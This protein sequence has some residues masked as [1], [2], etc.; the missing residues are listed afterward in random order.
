[1]YKK[2]KH[3]R[4][5]LFENNSPTPTS[6][7]LIDSLIEDCENEFINEEQL[8]NYIDESFEYEYQQLLEEGFIDILKA[9]GKTKAAIAAKHT[10]KEKLGAFVASIFASGMKILKFFTIGFVKFRFQMFAILL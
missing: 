5:F 10:I 9:P 2:P 7:V 6:E 1:M 4:G 3:T 8:F